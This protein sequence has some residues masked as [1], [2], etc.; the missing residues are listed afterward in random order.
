[1]RNNYRSFNG[2]LLSI[3]HQNRPAAIQET[4]I[5][6]L[7]ATFLQFSMHYTVKLMDSKRYL[8]HY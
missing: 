3:L 1:M 8:K 4:D 6:C 5:I 7:T 2:A